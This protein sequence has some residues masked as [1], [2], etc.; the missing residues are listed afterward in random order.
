MKD[1]RDSMTVY[2][3]FIIIIMSCAV[4]G[5]VPVLYPSRWSWSSH[6][7][8]GCPMLLF[9]FVL[10]FSACFSLHAVATLVGTVVFPEQ[11]SALQVSS[12]LIDFS[13]CLIWT[14]HRTWL[15]YGFLC[16]FFLLMKG[17]AADATDAPQPWGLLCNPVMKMTMMIIIFCPFPSNGAPVE[18]YWQGKTE[19]LGE[20][21]VPVQFCPPQIPHG[22]T[23]DRTRPPR[24]KAGD[25]APEPWHGLLCGLIIP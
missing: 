3:Q 16:G 6:L 12:S 23:R 20:K 4:L 17:P 15:T 21:P 10:H 8:L 7:F 2:E 22:L 14:I 24:W 9:P 13:P 18:W 1:S 11:C 19:V 25:E 5:A